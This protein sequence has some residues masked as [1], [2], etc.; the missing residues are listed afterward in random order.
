MTGVALTNAEADFALYL[1]WDFSS[2]P[3]FTQ[4][5][6]TRQG[7]YVCGIEPGNCIPE[8]QNAARANGRLQMIQPGETVETYLS[9]DI[10]E[11]AE[12]VKGLV[13]RIHTPRPD[14]R[15]LPNCR[16]EDYQST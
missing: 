15:P 12:A 8:G 3:Y 7:I 11:G 9:L 13:N 6:N 16:L 5:K 1:Q 4:W 10:V 2:L 14:A